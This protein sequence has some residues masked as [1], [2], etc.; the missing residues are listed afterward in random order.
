MKQI[1]HSHTL[2]HT[3][4]HTR[5]L[6]HTLSLSHSLTHQGLIGDHGGK[7]A[8]IAP[9]TK[10]LTS[11]ALH[12]H[13]CGASR[14]LLIDTAGGKG[15]ERSTGMA[16]PQPAATHRRR[17]SDRLTLVGRVERMRG[18]SERGYFGSCREFAATFSRCRG[19]VGRPR[20]I[21]FLLKRVDLH[22]ASPSSR[23]RSS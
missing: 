21:T 14:A 20:S 6:S 9:P 16:R 4:S 7:G 3:L 19:D 1:R 18:G 17:P 23:S 11:A 15:V 8:I 13:C 10:G 5:T 22:P 2:S 12:V